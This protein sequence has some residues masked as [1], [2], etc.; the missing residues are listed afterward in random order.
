MAIGA[1][2]RAHGRNARSRAGLSNIRAARDQTCGAILSPLSGLGNLGL[3]SHGLRRGLSSYGASA[4]AKPTAD[5]AARLGRRVEDEEED[6]KDLRWRRVAI[7]AVSG[8]SQNNTRDGT[9]PIRNRDPPCGL[10]RRSVRASRPRYPFL[11]DC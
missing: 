7:S 9:I 10:G 8:R 6:E 1:R 3:L 5:L 2:V 11:T 4:F